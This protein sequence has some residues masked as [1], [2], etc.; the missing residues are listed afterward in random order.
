MEDG[1]AIGDSNIQLSK[2]SAENRVPCCV[3][4]TESGITGHGNFQNW[5][6]WL[7]RHVRIL[8]EKVPDRLNLKL[9]PVSKQHTQDSMFNEN[10]LMQYIFLIPVKLSHEKR[11]KH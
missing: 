2:L 5:P 7:L 1:R 6:S 9:L 10:I 8:T 4:Y 11:W 3:N